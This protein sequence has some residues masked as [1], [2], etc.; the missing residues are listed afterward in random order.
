MEIEVD[1]PRDR[2]WSWVVLV[3]K[4]KQLVCKSFIDF[5]KF[6]SWS[7]NRK[8]KKKDMIKLTRVLLVVI[9]S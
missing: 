5:L 7:L 6:D 3:G 9:A 4:S 2:G 1:W 8:E